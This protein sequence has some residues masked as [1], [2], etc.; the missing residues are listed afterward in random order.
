MI[1]ILYLKGYFPQGRS[2]GTGFI[3]R[4]SGELKLIP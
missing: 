2:Q 3:L 1:E 4:E